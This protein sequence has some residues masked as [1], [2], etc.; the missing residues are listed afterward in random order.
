MVLTVPQK[1]YFI[2]PYRD[3]GG[4][5]V[6]FLRLSHAIAENNDYRCVLVDYADGYMSQR[7]NRDL[8]EV[9]NYENDGRVKIEDDTIVLFQSMSPWSI[10][11]GLSI[12]GKTRVLFWNC[13][14]ANLIPTVPQFRNVKLL[15]SPVS[16]YLTRL[17]LSSFSR[18]LTKFVE[19]LINHNGLVFMDYENV[20]STEIGLGLTIQNPNYLPIPAI[21]QAMRKVVARNKTSIVNVCWVGR[22]V[23]FKYFI[24][25]RLL[26]DLSILADHEALVFDVTIVGDGSHLNQLKDY[27]TGIESYNINFIEHLEESELNSF[28]INE[29]DILCA[30]G[31]SALEGAKFGVPTILLDIAYSEVPETYVYRWL[32]Q[33]D[34][35]TL[36]ESLRNY[37]SN[38][39][40]YNSLKRLIEE[41]SNDESVISQ[42]TYTYFLKNHSLEKVVEKLLGALGQSKCLWGDLRTKGLISRGLIYPLYKKIKRV[43]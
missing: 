18:K 8:V 34:G 26:D 15:S 25:K 3:V 28:L 33:R 5:S 22:I 37:K 6:L 20:K 13:H 9:V 23:D 40:S 1:I 30:M 11:P 32:F 12:S 35:S 42:R 27:S 39:C 2:F 43:L 19:H 31:T 36:G 21:K 4:V 24:L 7:A 38:G 16:T 17:L 29:V 41:C 10:F 14:P